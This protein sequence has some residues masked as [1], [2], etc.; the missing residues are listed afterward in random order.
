MSDF[1]T[2]AFEAVKQ[3]FRDIDCRVKDV[4]DT[5]FEIVH[6]Q[7]PAATLINP[8]A[9]Y[10]EYATLM[11]A[12]PNGFFQRFRS[13]RDALL[14]EANKKAHI[15]K[16]TCDTNSYDREVGGWRLQATARM[17][18]GTVTEEYRT[19]AIK[20]W[21]NLWLQDLAQIVLIEGNFQIVALMKK[22][23]EA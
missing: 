10:V 17:V 3:Q 8:T 5:H 23:K 6:D 11:W 4:S 20:N 13:L 7:F 22:S 2:E 14:N 21:T 15:T 16:I 9:Y 18:T 12:R 1:S 19:E